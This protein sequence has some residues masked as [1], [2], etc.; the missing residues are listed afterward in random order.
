MLLI[1]LELTLCKEIH[2]FIVDLVFCSKPFT[3]SNIQLFNIR[4]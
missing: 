4:N 3:L 2:N 1:I